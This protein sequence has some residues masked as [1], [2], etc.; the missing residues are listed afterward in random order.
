M[1]DNPY[2]DIDNPYM[3]VKAKKP[4]PML[5]DAVLSSEFDAG[6][7]DASKAI[8]EAAATIGSGAASWIPAGLS[9]FS[10]DTRSLPERAKTAT[11]I[12]E[13]LTYTPK[14]EAARKLVE[15]VSQVFENYGIAGREYARN[16]KNPYLA[17]LVHTGTE[18]IPFLVPVALKG[19]KG[20][21][22]AGKELRSLE[23]VL[24]P[25]SI[26]SV[27]VFRQPMAARGGR[28]AAP[29]RKATAEGT[30]EELMPGKETDNP[31][32]SVAT[33]TGLKETELTSK[34]KMERRAEEEIDSVLKK[35]VGSLAYEKVPE[36]VTP[37]E[38]EVDA[39]FNALSEQV[40]GMAELSERDRKLVNKAIEKDRADALEK[41]RQESEREALGT[42]PDE[43]IRPE[44][45]TKDTSRGEIVEPGATS[46]VVNRSVAFNPTEEIPVNAA[47]AEIK[48][49]GGL[50]IE[51]LRGR[52]SQSQ[53]T[54][55]VK[56]RPGLVSK[57][58][59]ATL[60]EIADMHR[61]ES[62]DALL[63]DILGAKSKKAY[64][65]A[66]KADI[67]ARYHDEMKQKVAVGDLKEGDKVVIDGEEFKHTGYDTEGNA[68]IKDGETIVADP[69]EVLAVDKIKKAGYR[70]STQDIPG[71]SER[72][73][74]SLTESPGMVGDK[75]IPK[76]SDT[77]TL[78][79]S[80]IDPTRTREIFNLL[81]SRA[82][83]TTVAKAIREMVDKF[84]SPEV[85]LRRTETGKRIYDTAD[86]ADFQHKK[87]VA[88]R[89]TEFEKAAKGITE[90]ES[91]R[92]GQ[93]LDGK[94]APE[95]LSEKEGRFYR[96]LKQQF[97][98]LLHRYARSAAGS[99]EAYLKARNL[100]NAKRKPMVKVSDLPE[101]KQSYY[102]G[103]KDP[104][105]RANYLHEAWKETQDEGFVKAFDALSRE[106]RDYLPHLFDK[107]Q[108]LDAF[109]SEKAD[110]ERKIQASPNDQS[111]KQ[112][113][114][115][116]NEVSDAIVTLE[117]GGWVRFKQLPKNLRFK[118]F[119][120]RRGKEGY[121][122]DAIKAYRSYL[123]GIARKI[124]D[125]PAVREMGRLYED[126]SPEAKTYAD[127]FIR[128]FAGK[129]KTNL[130]EL[131]N[132]ITSAQWIRTMGFNPRSALVNFTQRINTIADI[133]PEYSLK[134]QKLAFTKEG[135]KLFDDT[136][137]AAEVP[138][139]LYEGGSPKFEK[140]RALSAIM[141]N[142]VELG[143]RRHA[144][145]SGY[146]KGKEKLGLGE[147]A[148]IQY[149][150]DAANRT[151]FRYGRVGT[152]E[153]MRNPAGRVAFQFMSYPIKQIEFLSDLAKRDPKRF[154]GW[155]LMA[156]GGNLALQEFLDTDLSNAMGV[157]ITWAEALN[158]FKD[159]SKGDIR[160]AFR[161]TKLAVRP[162]AGLLPTGLGPTA[163]GAVKVVQAIPEGKAM[164]TLKQEL[165]PVMANRL[166][167]AGK[168]VAGEK[169][170]QYPIIS[171]R[172]D[173]P[174][175]RLTGR[176]LAQR[177]LGPQTATER[178]VY[179][180]RD[181]KA[182]L[183]KDRKA[184]TREIIDKFLSGDLKGA[185]GLAK[186]TG[187]FPTNQQIEAAR[188]A[189]K[190]TKEE[191]RKTR[192]PGKAELYEFRKEGRTY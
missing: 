71:F 78:F 113:K 170:G 185:K 176:Q 171:S 161:H 182:S 68:I 81:A 9:M 136:G 87:F 104:Q 84:H 34:E 180:N 179:L 112:F 51:S 163:T 16:I 115:R 4:L 164:Q 7:A 86:K 42:A 159:L 62:G 47:L 66:E 122:F 59:K 186:E 36:K 181:R 19:V 183:E 114:A 133:G 118:F 149:G 1:S 21:K 191:I 72:E 99:E 175:V 67:E 124:F 33:D 151:Q 56:K 75:V 146:L 152:P 131:A 90:E 20:V 18:A 103:L 153:I 11:D 174:L 38:R 27:P 58:G 83:D 165:T 48:S 154:V 168:A 135:K 96:Y 121:S 50:N 15:P 192:R 111:V 49:M 157:G 65:E 172:T 148:A 40:G 141:F 140:I 139:V 145:L 23:G 77:E 98:F 61:Y 93:A 102:K 28:T 3:G 97:S 64:A 46:G 134:G 142:R 150:I 73:T 12:Q 167:Q 119:E 160:E 173:R 70:E 190:F 166:I 6:N 109:K 169:N 5:S 60:D 92:V 25:S 162:G 130:E 108:L 44:D 127:S 105:E 74:F 10:F 129:R 14:S 107:D 177:T 82:K 41:A 76:G 116:L 155:M 106:L 8:L 187:V 85:V 63:Q 94:L 35:E 57:N 39:Y 29:L 178:T 53:I 188:M 89:G 69:F 54:E 2:M 125:E 120:P 101:G 91:A 17:T 31:Y 128:H 37:R 137:L 22:T 45:M 110:L 52:Y 13:A 143:N 95:T 24:E 158:A 144:F 126:I 189:R 132:A 100:A 26:E 30:P 138:Q 80:W 184:I 147:S 123:T 32:L 55:L 43:A 79:T 117:G 88:E 156:E